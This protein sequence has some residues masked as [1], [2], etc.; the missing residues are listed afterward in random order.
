M[1]SSITIILLC[2]IFTPVLFADDQPLTPEQIARLIADRRQQIENYYEQQTLEVALRTQKELSQLEIDDSLV[3]KSLKAHT[4]AAELISG[5]GT[6][7]YMNDLWPKPDNRCDTWKIFQPYYA[8]AQS[9]DTLRE[10][11]TQ[12]F[13]RRFVQAKSKINEAKTDI[14]A[15]RRA[16]LFE[17]EI[18]K[19][20]ALTVGLDNY[21]N[22]LQTPPAVQKKIENVISGI[23][24]SD[25]MPAAFIN[26]KILYTNDELDD[27]IKITA[28][29]KD[30]VEFKKGSKT[31]SRTIGEKP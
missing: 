28:I 17:L 19:Q 25:D 8:L 21:K 23:L 2:V 7:Y 15:K 9:K 4:I 24:F 22:R 12:N 31:W 26:G 10:D 27:E 11:F 16:A 18:Q 29:N 6:G 5:I 13:T 3:Y 14:M 20:N 1:K 30:S